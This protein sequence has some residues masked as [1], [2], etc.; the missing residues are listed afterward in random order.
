M[1][2]SVSV[3]PRLWLMVLFGEPQQAEVGNAAA[4]ISSVFANRAVGDY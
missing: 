3:P 2:I 1:G 4:R